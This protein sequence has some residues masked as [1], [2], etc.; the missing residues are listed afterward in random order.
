MQLVCL[1]IHYHPF[2]GSL[3]FVLL[4]Y[5]ILSIGY[6]SMPV[7]EK[8]AAYDIIWIAGLFTHYTIKDG[9]HIFKPSC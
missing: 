9:V 6:V 4:L 3:L 8:P 7:T 1:F 2:L 5:L